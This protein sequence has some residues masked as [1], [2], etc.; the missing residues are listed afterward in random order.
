MK[1][2]DLQEQIESACDAQLP[3][4]HNAWDIPMAQQFIDFSTFLSSINKDVN[5]I[6]QELGQFYLLMD[7]AGCIDLSE[8]LA[9]LMTIQNYE[10]YFTEHANYYLGISKNFKVFE[11]KCTFI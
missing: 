10:E 8:F 7:K 3:R 1:S 6:A 9:A 5:S 2:N 4:N 11:R